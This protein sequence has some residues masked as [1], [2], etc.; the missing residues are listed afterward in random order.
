MPLGLFC[1][2]YF[3]RLAGDCC[4]NGKG[5]TSWQ[6][7]QDLIEVTRQIHGSSHEAP[8]LL[9]CGCTLLPLYLQWEGH[10]VTIAGIRRECYTTNSGM[11][12]RYHLIIFDP[13]KNGELL[14]NK[15]NIELK[16][17][18]RETNAIS[19]VELAC[20]KLH[21]KDTQILVSS[22]RVMSEQERERCK[23][24]V[25]CISFVM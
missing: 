20:D 13:Q 4:G 25:G 7:V 11:S 21:F 17:G 24:R 18:Q 22:E 8:C 23:E 2:G 3:S 16:E 12:I 1:W 15:L 9:S 10:S 19:V 6:Y 5:V 14:L